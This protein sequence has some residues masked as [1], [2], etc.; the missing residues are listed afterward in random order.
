[1]N[2]CNNNNKLWLVII[3]NIYGYKMWM[4]C[5][6]SHPIRVMKIRKKFNRYGNLHLQLL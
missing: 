2:T 3:R 4:F 1:M 6:L 5:I